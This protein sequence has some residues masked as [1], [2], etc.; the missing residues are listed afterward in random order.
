M[1]ELIHFHRQH[2]RD[3]AGSALCRHF[4]ECGNDPLRFASASEGGGRADVSEF[5]PARCGNARL[6]VPESQVRVLRR[7]WGLRNLLGRV[8][9]L[10]CT[11]NG[12]PELS[13]GAGVSSPVTGGYRLFAPDLCRVPGTT[14]G[15]GIDPHCVGIGKRVA[16]D[17]GGCEFV[18]AAGESRRI[19]P[20]PGTP[21]VRTTGTFP[22]RLV[23]KD[24]ICL[25][26]KPSC[27]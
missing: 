18:G 9:A 16:A 4:D 12:G 3:F 10:L 19:P 7:A 24:R 11:E 21:P 23:F 27:M 26:G 1:A 8:P 5:P 6:P 15:Q 25:R 17:F 13:L 20:A 14:H 2:R 22:A